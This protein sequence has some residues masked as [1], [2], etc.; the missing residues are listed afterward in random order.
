MT[1]PTDYLIVTVLVD[2]EYRAAMCAFGRNPNDESS[3]HVGAQPVHRI[4]VPSPA[5]GASTHIALTC[6]VA[7]GNVNAK[8]DVVDLVRTLKP[9]QVLLVGTACGVEGANQV[10]DVVV[11]AEG[12]LYYETNYQLG[13]ERSRHQQP[14]PR[15]SMVK[16]FELFYT[17]FAHDHGW[18]KE[19]E[20]TCDVLRSLGDEVPPLPNAMPDVHMKII[21]SGEKILA[22]GTM[23][24]LARANDQ[25]AAGD[26]EAY[27]F[28]S[29]CDD[30]NVDWMVI[31]G[32]SDFG[33]REQR[34]RYA[35]LASASAASYAFAYLNWRTSGQLSSQLPADDFFVRLA[36]GDLFRRELRDLGI[37]LASI[38]RIRN[39]TASDLSARL[40]AAYPTRQSQE[41]R[42]AVSSARARAFDGKYRYPDPYL[43]ERELDKDAWI[44][45]I[46]ST[47]DRLGP[48]SP[49]AAEV[50]EVGCGN[51]VASELLISTFDKYH[52]VDIA[53]SALG[54]ASRKYP[55]ARFSVEEAEILESVPSASVDL[56]VSLRTYQ[57]AL[58]GVGSALLQAFRV[59]KPGGGIL[60][61][62]PYKYATR[63]GVVEGLKIPG[64]SAVDPELPYTY[65]NYIRQRLHRFGFNDIAMK[66]GQVEVFVH[67]RRP[68]P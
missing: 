47:L 11:S 24:E 56:Y 13:D 25:V 18:S 23:A 53:E 6:L 65:A 63:G 55:A 67:G 17:K 21:A 29:A 64:T 16:G 66:T 3:E 59:L 12:V 43:D 5:G 1:Q 58:F 48:Y 61:S 51:G 40:S 7:K 49:E 42:K 62:I 36:I 2:S 45:E 35:L 27:G 41:V 32:V 28:A 15:A 22:P 44:D 4:E 19:L 30:E 60:I 9:K 14:Q 54:D 50:L 10:G 31:R 26:Q 39:S 68:G 33:D 57:S 46:Q 34:K 52:G 38:G 37:E 8:N 20:R